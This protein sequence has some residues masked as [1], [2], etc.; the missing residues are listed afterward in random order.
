MLT[1][2]YKHIENFASNLTWNIKVIEHEYPNP[3]S[4]D[5]LH[6]PDCI[7]NQT[8]VSPPDGVGVCPLTQP[9]LTLCATLAFDHI[10]KQVLH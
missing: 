9:V 5:H 3:T 2:L 7:H 1:F 6:N 10:Y 8:V 4:P